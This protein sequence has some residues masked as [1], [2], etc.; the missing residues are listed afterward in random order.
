MV[1]VSGVVEQPPRELL[2]SSFRR[3]F[4]ERLLLSERRQSAGNLLSGPSK[5]RFVAADFRRWNAERLQLREDE[6]VNS[7]S[8]WKVRFGPRP[9]EWNPDA[10]DSDLAGVRCDDGRFADPLCSSDE[11]PLIDF[12]NRGFVRFEHDQTGDVPRRTV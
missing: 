2:A 7:V 12:G 3:L 8:N 10:T 5:K 4:G 11:S 9:V 6:L 1:G